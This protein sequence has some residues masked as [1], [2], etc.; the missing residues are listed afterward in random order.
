MLC[1]FVSVCK[2]VETRNLMVICNFLQVNAFDISSCGYKKHDGELQLHATLC[3]NCDSP[4]VD[5]V[6]DQNLI[7][8]IVDG[9]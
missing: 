5:V 7:D 3:L 4:M 2:F 9:C 1:G 6:I 8:V